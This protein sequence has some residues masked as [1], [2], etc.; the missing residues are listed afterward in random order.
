M[1]LFGNEIYDGRYYGGTSMRLGIVGMLP[2]DFRAFQPA[3]MQAIRDLGF[4]GFG[5]HL[6]G[7]DVFAITAGDCAGYRHFMAA[8]DLDLAQFAITYKECLFAV[9]PAPRERVIAKIQRA[10]E[11]AAQLGRVPDRVILPVGGGGLSSGVVSYFGDACN[12][13]FV[14]P[15][16]A[17]SLARALE[18]ASHAPPPLHQAHY[19]LLP[20]HPQ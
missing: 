20:G 4:T 1:N 16:G 10:T 12:Y 3:Q 17:P 2:G 8:E 11:I 5:F 19:L 7:D 6:D 18:A 15:A 14:E 9:D 13:T